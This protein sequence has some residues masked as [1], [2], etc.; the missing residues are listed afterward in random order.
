MPLDPAMKALL[1]QLAAQPAPKLYEV[2]IVDARAIFSGLLKAVGA[3]NAP[4]GKLSN[5]GCP[6][7]AGEIPLRIYTPV[8]ATSEAMPTLVYFHGG[9]FVVGDLDA[10]DGLCRMLANDTRVRVI[11]V[12]YRLAP[13]HKYPAAIE[14]SYAALVYIEANAAELGVDANRIAVGGDSAGGAIAA[15]VTQ[16]ARD[17]GGPRIAFQLLLFPVMQI[18]EETNSLRDHAEGCFL[19]RSTL[20]WFYKCYLPT[21][22][23]TRDARISPLA[24]ASL[25]GLP[26]A[27][28]MTAEFDPLHDEGVRYAKA[29]LRAGVDVT[30]AD[31]PGLVHNFIYFQATLPQAAQALDAAATA[32]RK[33]LKAG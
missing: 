9:G 5:V 14:D 25:S 30:I 2:A 26:P 6:G 7:P 3:Q 22:A 21:G 10:Y 24:V 19:E 20:D 16:M 1:D 4:I 23:D 18:G 17:S 12:D 27:Y 33:A 29:L 31:Y 11:A 8:A 13:E 32:L 28:L 15:V